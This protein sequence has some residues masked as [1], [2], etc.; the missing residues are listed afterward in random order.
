MAG[1]VAPRAVALG[2]VEH[3]DRDALAVAGG[4]RLEV[5]EARDGPGGGLHLVGRGVVT[6]VNRAP[7]IAIL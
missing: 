1:V 4:E 5:D 7:A 6:L 3:D 2:G